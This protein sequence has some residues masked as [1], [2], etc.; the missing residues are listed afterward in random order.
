MP[1]AEQKTGGTM[2]LWEVEINRES[3]DGRKYECL[4]FEELL[5][6]EVSGSADNGNACT[7]DNFLNGLENF[8]HFEL[9]PFL[10]NI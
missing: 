6:H 3:E 2:M 1:P 10:D 5:V 4:L 9:S 8:L 7:N